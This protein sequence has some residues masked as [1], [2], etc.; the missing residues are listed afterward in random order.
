MKR[1]MVK[2]V[3]LSLLSND[4]A[5]QEQLVQ[6]QY[7]S[8][9]VLT[10]NIEEAMAANVVMISSSKINP[11]ELASMF[12][13]STYKRDSKTIFFYLMETLESD[14]VQFNIT[15]ICKTL[16]INLI[17]ALLTANQISERIIKHVYP[18]VGF[19]N[20]NVV[21]F[22]GADSKVGTT[23]VSLC[24]A[25]KL[26]LSTGAKILYI[27]LDDN[28][29]DIYVR[30]PEHESVSLDALK[31]KLFNKLLTVD[32]LLNSCK[33]DN[34]L[35]ILQGPTYLPDLKYYH[36][37]HLEY[38][39]ELVKD[40]MDLVI[41]DAGSN[42]ERGMCVGALR[43]T[44]LRY[45]VT[46]QQESPKRQFDRIESQILRALQIRV[47]D[48]FVV[49]NKYINEVSQYSDDKVADLY[50][51]T[52][53]CNLPNLDTLGW[54]AEI[55]N[56]SLLMYNHEGYDAQIQHLCQLIANQTGIPFTPDIRVKK[57]GFFSRKV[58]GISGLFLGGG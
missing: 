38:I 14:V 41:I 29:V 53:A 18:E 5:L 25:Q 10:G 22:F 33:K 17:P 35:Y 3:K 26:A 28:S 55:D 47:R 16:R 7:F 42:F 37:E 44:H 57:K 45:L 1:R 6:S 19:K 52:L 2:T 24:A 50:K 32:E 4:V 58:A 48:F 20:R 34:G 13:S 43:A 36:P 8:E 9:V 46:T 27:P 56:Q 15:S 54:Q 39:L 49:V 40:E 21:T 51:M 12:T 31:V 23:M 11:N 30:A